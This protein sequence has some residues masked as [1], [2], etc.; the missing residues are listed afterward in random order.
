MY[1]DTFLPA[2]LNPPPAYRTLPDT[3]SANTGP[4]IPEPSADQPLPFHLAIPL[5][6]LPPA[7]VKSP[8]P[9]TGRYSTPPAQSHCRSSPNPEPTNRSRSIWQRNWPR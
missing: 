4:F 2:V 8:P 3:A 7:V 5:A 6:A 9:H 1:A